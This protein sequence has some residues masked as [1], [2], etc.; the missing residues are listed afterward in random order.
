MKTLLVLLALFLPF[1][2]SG[3][4]KVVISEWLTTG[5]LDLMRP[6]FHDTPNV[7]GNK[8]SDRQLLNHDQIDLS[9]YFPEAGKELSWKHGHETT[10][11]VLVSD[12]NGFVIISDEESADTPRLAYLATYIRTERW[13]EASLELMSP[14]MLEA[15]LNGKK[16]GTKSTVEDD[17]ES[18]GRVSHDVKLPTGTHL[19]LIKMLRPAGT[20]MG[21]KLQGSL[22]VE[23][24]YTASDIR[25]GTSPERI[26]H[27]LD[28][29]DGVKITSV[30]PSPDGSMYLIRYRQSLPPSDR[31]EN[32]AEI[33]RFG[34]NE[35]VHS[36]RHANVARISWLP[37]TNAVSYTFTRDGKTTVYCHH[38]ETGNI[39]V[40]ADG[41]ENFTGMSWSP[42]MSY[43]VYSVREEGSGADAT[44]RQVLGMQDRQAQFRHRSFLYKLDLASGV[45]TRLTFGNLSTNLHDISPDGSKMVFSQ[46][47]PDYLE[48]PYLKHDLF[49]MDMHDFSVDTLVANKRWSVSVRFSP[50][51]NYLLATGGP[52]AFDRIGENIPE[53]MISNNY[54]TQAYIFSLQNRSVNPITFDFD[55]NIASAHWHPSDN[56]IYLLGGDKDYRRL[57]RYN[58][59][60]ERFEEIETDSEYISSISFASNARVAT[61]I[62]N[63]A[64]AHPRSYVINLRNDRFELLKDTDAKRYRHV[65]YGDV[66]EWDFTAST[67]VNISGRY[68][69]P[70]DFDPEKQYPLIVYQYGG[71]N[72]VSR[73]FGSRYPLNIWAGHGYVVYVLQ[74]S[75]ATGFGQE[76]SAAHVNNWGITVVDEIIEGTQQFIEAHPFVDSER[77]GVAGASYG[78]FMTMLLLSH[79]DMFATGISHAGI[80]N[81]ASYWGDGYWGYSYSAEATARSFPWNSHEIYV[82]QSPLFRADNINTPLLLVTGDSDTNVPPGESIQMYTALKLL[83]R[84]VELVL[85]EG[86]NHHILTYNKRLQWHDVIM[87]WWDKHLKGEPEWWKEQF[88][89]KNY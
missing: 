65:V 43:F 87:A 40:L 20:E 41:I 21:W 89:E 84:E 48:R 76:F 2:V 1:A 42:D 45:S 31:S 22:K 53:G 66:N 32:W 38:M 85:V 78:G 74:P 60:R 11:T 18:P 63:R 30:Q 68:Y 16:I 50:N 49:I 82:G 23:E 4:E 6:A 55:P 3:S 46:T 10:W 19:L 86:E 77:I 57:Y 52:S 14:Y 24:P 79:T 28:F 44:I 5:S 39:H 12:A 27:I 83:G 34:N 25:A 64:N 37:L 47:R 75:G 26:K 62:G 70:P 88:P 58:V 67:G 59:R 35:L 69:L 61:F 72:P 13:L 9:D 33:R 36:F 71:T 7:E 17:E 29:M 54:D 73:S 15:Q 51:G 56:N 80:S 81:L 8:F